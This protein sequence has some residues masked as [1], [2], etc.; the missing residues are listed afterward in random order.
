MGVNKIRRKSLIGALMISLIVGLLCG[1]YALYAITRTLKAPAIAIDI[2]KPPKAGAFTL[3]K[4]VPM[5]SA[6]G[7]TDPATGKMMCRSAG[8]EGD[9]IQPTASVAKLITVL[10]TLQHNPDIAKNPDKTIVLTKADHER[11]LWNINN[12]GSSVAVEAGQTIS[13]RQILQG[14][15]LKSANNLADTLV[16]NQFGDQNKYQVVA[17]AWLKQ[18]G[19]NHTVVGKDASG[20]HPSTTSSATD[21]CRLGLLTFKYP[22]IMEILGQSTATM[23]SGE[24]IKTTNKMLGQSDIIGGK[25]GYNVEAGYNFV[26]LRRIIKDHHVINS[27]IVSL[28]N[29]HFAESFQTTAV[30]AELLDQNIG[31]WQIDKNT[32]IGQ[33]ASA[34]AGSSQLYLRD[35]ISFTYW[36]D[37]PPTKRAINRLI[38]VYL[39][40]G[41]LLG[42]TTFK[43]HDNNVI[44]PASWIWRLQHPFID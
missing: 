3:D 41:P 35:S 27:A 7:F 21:L 38:D 26:G 15:L 1:G 24:A 44:R 12:N 39:A 18:Q 17:N 31:T 36:V 13:Y 23:P 5:R 28:A 8:A 30:L 29:P 6:I 19:L 16:D 32:P 14:I 22:L 43:V 20:Y 9:F 40:E 4:P 37:A 2:I 33:V 34:W 25:T 11:W 42:S 10:V